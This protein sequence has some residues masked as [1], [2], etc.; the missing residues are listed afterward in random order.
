VGE[1]S[2]S[3]IIVAYESRATIA[4]CL[5]SI[6][7]HAGIP[8][9]TIVVDNA[10]SDGTAEL[11]REGFPEVSLLPQPTNRGFAA[12][13]NIG[14]GVATA[15][16]LLFLNPDTE[17]LPGALPELARLMEAAPRVA[18]AGPRLVYPDHTPQDSAFRYPTLLMTWLEFFPRP[19]RLIHS[20]LNGRISAQD[21]RPVPVD[22]PLGACMLVRRG[23]WDDVGPFDEGFFLYCEEVDWCMRAKAAGWEVMHVPTATVV[24]HGGA[25]AASAPAASFAHLHASRARLHAKHRGRG[26]QL[27]ARWITRLGLAV[28]RRRLCRLQRQPRTSGAPQIAERLAGVERAL[29]TLR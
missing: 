18:A 5:I 23:A 28:E 8:V 7:D 12:S 17:L 19:G 2:A 6:A 1:S 9:Q 22:H 25:S 16:Y 29:Q 21:G 3:I 26:F 20:A 14:A 13:C 11:V 27:A 4:A 10:S 24:H 15:P